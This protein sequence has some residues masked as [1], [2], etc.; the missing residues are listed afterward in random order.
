MAEF[1]KRMGEWC[2]MVIEAVG[3]GLIVVLAIYALT[4][5]QLSIT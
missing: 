2:A 3:V 5:E 4:L 1:V